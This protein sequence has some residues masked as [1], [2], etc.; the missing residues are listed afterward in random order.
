MK[1]PRFKSYTRP[2]GHDEFLEFFISLSEKDKGK[3]AA[4][5]D[6][7]QSHGLEIAIRLEWVKKLDK[8]LYEIRSKVSSNIQRAVYFHVEDNQYMITHGFTKKTQKTPKREIEH[9]KV[10]RA[11]YWHEKEGK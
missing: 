7:I 9:A 1:K 11:E 8:N 4:Q 6:K 10:I 2:N 3:L 5:I